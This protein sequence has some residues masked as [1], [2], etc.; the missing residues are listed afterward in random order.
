VLCMIV[1]MA[2]QKN[3][4]FILRSV[5]PI[6]LLVSCASNSV[7][8]SFD[9]E[10]QEF[11]SKVRYIISKDE[12][13]AF[14]HLPASE[15][16]GFID[17]FWKKRDTNPLTDV[18]EFKVEYDKRINEANLLFKE[19]T[20]PG[21]LQD[22]GWL[23]ILLGPPSNRE[24]YPRG[25]TFYGKPTEI[26]YYGFFPVVFIDDNWSGY[27]R[28]DAGSAI[29]VGELIK[30]VAMLIPK[31]SSDRA[32]ETLEVQ[33]EVKAIKEGEA[34]LQVKITYKNIW[35]KAE[36][37]ALKT[38]LDVSVVLLDSTGKKAWEHSQSHLLA[39]SQKEFLKLIQEDYLLEV[40]I[41]A[42]PGTY[43]MKFSL[44]NTTDGSQV[45]KTETLNL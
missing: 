19:G 28:L 25:T 26:W 13:N 5:F 30:T 14:L 31:V 42:T 23:Y 7:P 12:R 27:Y 16:P 11:L 36:G 10:S 22:R 33:S 9:P 3:E 21:W 43:T 39:L 17:E 24:T 8:K 41:E 38:T 32:K 35:L 40:R 18:N 15:R 37:D 44:K 45:Q 20:T 29:Q 6:L 2:P 34:R 1:K 4:F